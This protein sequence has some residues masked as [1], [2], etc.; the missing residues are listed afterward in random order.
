MNNTY[1]NIT[2]EEIAP[3]SLEDGPFFHVW[4]DTKKSYVKTKFI[5]DVEYCK[6]NNCY[7]IAKTLIQAIN[8]PVFD[9]EAIRNAKEEFA[10]IKV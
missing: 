4:D 8:A 9:H 3:L 6:Y 5:P 2:N 10:K 1:L 7:Q